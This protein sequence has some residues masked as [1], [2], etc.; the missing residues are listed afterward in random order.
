MGAN[1]KTSGKWSSKAT[2]K[3]VLIETDKGSR[4]PFYSHTPWAAEAEAKAYAN[5]NRMDERS[6]TLTK[7]VEI[8]KRGMN[9]DTAVTNMHS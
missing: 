2:W 7:P 4:L 8:F 1:A 5:A 3:C 6:Y 9:W